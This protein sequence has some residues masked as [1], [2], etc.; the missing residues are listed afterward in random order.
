MNNSLI[1]SLS[2]SCH[3][4]V[5]I[6][7]WGRSGHFWPR[8]PTFIRPAIP[9]SYIHIIVIQVNFS[10]TTDYFKAWCWRDHLS[11]DPTPPMLHKHWLSW[12]HGGI[13]QRDRYLSTFFGPCIRITHITHNIEFSKPDKAFSESHGFH[14]DTRIARMTRIG[15]LDLCGLSTI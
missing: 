13:G 1:L 15:V 6:T 7:Q 11:S 9:V 3:Y 4:N 10:N 8:L 5:I 14:D 12:V 2:V